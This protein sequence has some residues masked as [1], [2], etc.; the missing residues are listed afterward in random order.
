VLSAGA[1]KD[2]TQEI[3]AP[4][5]AAVMRYYRMLIQLARGVASGG[6]RSASTPTP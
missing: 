1:I 4:A 6:T 5:D 2:R 3:L